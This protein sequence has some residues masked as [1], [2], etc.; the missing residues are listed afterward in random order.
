MP[1]ADPAPRG[2]RPRGSSASRRHYG[3]KKPR[4]FCAARLFFGDQVGLVQATVS[5]GNQC[6][7]LCTTG[8]ITP[9]NSS[10]GKRSG[11]HFF[12][13]RRIKIAPERSQ[14]ASVSRLF[15]RCRPFAAA[16]LARK[17]PLRAYIP[18][19][20]RTRTARA[21]LTRE[22]SLANRCGVALAAMIKGCRI[23][24]LR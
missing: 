14:N 3:K 18:S 6:R 20:G 8:Q 22:P 15:R 5:A 19:R 24:G 4:G 23:N 11:R 1:L 13:A 9:F 21:A 12:C 10:R 17:L 16:L 2:T 7:S